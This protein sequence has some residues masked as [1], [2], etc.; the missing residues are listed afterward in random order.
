[1]SARP[2][3]G[4]YPDPDD[5]DR[6]RNWDGA[7]W[8]D[9]VSPLGPNPLLQA[10]DEP[11]R[12]DA[13]PPAGAPFT[14]V[15]DDALASAASTTEVSPPAL[16]LATETPDEVGSNPFAVRTRAKSLILTIVLWLHLGGLGVHNYYVG[17][18][19]PAIGQTAVALLGAAAILVIS[20]AQIPGP[21]VVPIVVFWVLGVWIV[22]DAFF[23]RQWADEAV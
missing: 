21:P 20:V 9:K 11:L 4:W 1:M 10:R 23:L 16:T 18:I 15:E 22:V 19:R 12:T 5:V 2:A 14:A 3:R 6:Q 13:A 7:A 8:T 17:R